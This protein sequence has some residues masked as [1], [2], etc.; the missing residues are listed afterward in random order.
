MKN[1]LEKIKC[2]AMQEI[3]NINLDIYN[4]FIIYAELP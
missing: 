3:Y 4:L 1:K 2:I